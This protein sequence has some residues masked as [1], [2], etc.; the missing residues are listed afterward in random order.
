MK[1]LFKN[2]LFVVLLCVSLVIVTCA[3]VFNMK[4]VRV[5]FVE[6]AVSVIIKPFQSAITYSVNGVNGFF[7]RVLPHIAVSPSE[8]TSEG[9]C[10]A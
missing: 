4:G 5:P 1:D 3:A 10:K 8:K 9:K 6:N 7:G 2:R